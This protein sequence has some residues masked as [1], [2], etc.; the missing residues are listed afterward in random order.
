M[1]FKKGDIVRYRWITLE[2]DVVCRID[3]ITS[4][5]ISTMIWLDVHVFSII[6]NNSSLING[7]K[8]DEFRLLYDRMNPF[9]S[10]YVYKDMDEAMVDML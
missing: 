10:I 7:K 5:P 9:M 8:K 3:D 2:R 4:T 6:S 1:E